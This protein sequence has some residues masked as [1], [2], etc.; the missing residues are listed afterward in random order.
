MPFFLSSALG[1]MV[2]DAVQEGWRQLS[3]RVGVRT[4]CH[5][6]HSAKR[7]IGYIWV[8]LWFSVTVPWYSFHFFRLYITENLTFS[9]GIADR[10]GVSAG[11]V[12][13]GV[14]AIALMTLFRPS[15]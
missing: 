12:A 3:I 5:W 8:L 4:D 2:E 14:G 7:V 15:I 11:S 6:I 10:L 9:R 13:V 1:I